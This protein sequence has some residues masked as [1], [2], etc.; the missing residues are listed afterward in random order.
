L[1]VK[2]EIILKLLSKFKNQFLSKFTQLSPL[3]KVVL[4]IF[5]LTPLIWYW[6]TN[7]FY[8]YILNI[9]GIPQLSALDLPPQTGPVLELV[10]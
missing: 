5:L 9:I 2:M 1:G 6:G 8:Y 7:L 3:K 4:I 10:L